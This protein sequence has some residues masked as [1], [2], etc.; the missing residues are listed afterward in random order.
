LLFTDYHRGYVQV[1]LDS[2]HWTNDFR[3][4]DTVR[5]AVAEAHTLATFVVENG[6]AGAQRARR[7][8]R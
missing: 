4:V 5:E 8:T 7:L 6:L 2:A 3:V 1:T